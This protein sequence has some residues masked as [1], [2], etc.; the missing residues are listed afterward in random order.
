MSAPDPADRVAWLRREI[1]R[2]ERLYYVH[3]APEIDDA[4]FDALFAE[5]VA[6]EAADPALVSADSPTQ[7]VAGVAGG[8]FAQ[9]H[10]PQPM[11]SLANA[12]SDA[13]LSAWAERARRLL[14]AA[15]LD[16]DV[17]YVTEPKI[18]G[19]AISLVYRDGTFDR[20]ATRGDGEVGDDVTANLRTV[21][22]VPLRL[23]GD[24]APPALLEARGEVYIPVAD[25]A[26]LNEQ[27]AQA[28]LDTFRTPRNSA[29]G[30]LRQKDPAV[31][32]GRPLAIWCYG[33]GALEGAEV[34]SH[35]AALE[36]LRSHGL[37]VN[38]LTAQHDDLESVA[39][40][41]A[42]IEA[43]RA[44][45][46]YEIDGVVIKIDRFDQQRALGSIGK[47]PRWAVAYKFAPTTATTRLLGIGIN[48][49]RTGA[50]NP[51]AMLEPVQVAG[52]IVQLA[53]LHNEDDIR[54]KDVR[55]GDTVIV[56]RAGDVIPQ[57]V[58]PLTSM[59]TGSEEPF[60]MPT[61]CPSCGGSVVRPAGEVV[62]RCTNVDCPSRGL[63]GLKHFVS[64]GAMDIDGVGEKL[65][66]RLWELGLVRR[67]PQLYGLTVDQ[68]LPLEGF[69]QRSA[70]NVVASIER[71]RERPFARVL[72]A[73]GM[74]HVGS[75]TAEQLA[76]S[77]GGIERLRAAGPD[78]I[79]ET[80]GVG[81]VIAEAVAAWFADPDHAALVDELTSAGLRMHGDAADE[82]PHDGP[83]GGL[84]LVITGTLPGWSRDDARAAV[85]ERGGKVA[86]SVSKRT[87]YVV[88][89]GS[90]GSKLAKAE[91]LGVPVLDADGFARLLAGEGP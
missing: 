50:L 89:G 83:L 85:V 25:F 10:H 44:E 22:S 21:R 30:S 86:D 77:F 8:G 42:E 32:S 82:I 57:V 27:R 62:H 64:R 88:A 84:T 90:P 35:T 31:T 38:P 52:V 49:G 63:E 7:R 59:R 33:V 43:L 74:P 34:A 37:R 14:A 47:D 23:A 41:C 70:E 26:R 91:A 11:L 16:E 66:L 80:E 18:D 55:I 12:R 5:L 45:L 1:E 75:V 9:V 60:S 28:G 69:Q 36:L 71:S 53:T 48:V 73:L 81:P 76:R 20:G 2:H 58:G 4:A 29:A 68:L 17:R 87:S 3:D 67:A 54:R 24:D 79:A 39:A 65:V 61:Q 78:E 46:D 13:E 72:F 40:R 19:L 6:F 15:G 51:Y 56:Q